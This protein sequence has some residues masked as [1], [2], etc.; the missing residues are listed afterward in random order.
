M[1]VDVSA[2]ICELG[3]TFGG[4]LLLLHRISFFFPLLSEKRGMIE[5]SCYCSTFSSKTVGSDTTD[6]T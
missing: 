4:D 3:N 6:L 2:D 5:I 1:E